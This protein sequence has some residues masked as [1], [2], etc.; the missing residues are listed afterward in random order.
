VTR[1]LPVANED[2]A[3]RVEAFADSLRF[4]CHSFSLELAICDGQLWLVDSKR[5]GRLNPNWPFVA[6]IAL[7]KITATLST[8]DKHDF[9][10]DF[11]SLAA[12]RAEGRDW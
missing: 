4:L 9:P 1:A 7:P 2:C 12:A 3:R 11:A 5:P 8:I 6:D 10:E